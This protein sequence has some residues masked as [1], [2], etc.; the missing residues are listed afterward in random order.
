MKMKGERKNVTILFTDISDFT[1]MSEKLDPEDVIN[2]INSCFDKLTKIIYR[3]EGTVDK[4]MGDCIIALFGAPVAHEDDPERAVK[5]AIEIIQTLDELNK[6][7]P[8][9]IQMHV[10]INTGLVVAGSIGSDLRKQYTVIGDTMNTASRIQS[11]AKR[12]QILVGETVYKLTKDVFYYNEVGEIT[13]KGKE[14]PLRVYAPL[15][16]RPQLT[17]FGKAMA[18]GLT[19]YIGREKELAILRAL[20]LRST[21]GEGNAVGI[22]G[23]P[24]IG[25]SRLLYE[26]MY[27]LDSVDDVLYL[28]GH[29]IP[30]GRISP[31]QPFLEVVRQFLG[32]S[33]Q[34]AEKE[35]GAFY[36]RLDSLKEYI[37]C[38]EDLLS[39]PPSNPEYIQL[40]P[41]VRRKKIFDA[42]IALFQHAAASKPLILVIEDIQWVDETSREF[43]TLLL[44]RISSFRILLILISRPEFNP[45]W[46][47]HDF[48]TSVSLSN[49]YGSEGEC[50]VHALFDAPVSLELEKFI[51]KRVEGNPFFTE[52]LIRVLRETQAVTLNGSYTLAVPSAK[53]NIPE[54]IQGVLAARIDRLDVETKSTL[55]IA[56][57]VGYET[58][59][60][61]LEKVSELKGHEL[62][63]QLEILAE[64]GFMVSQ[65]QKDSTYTFKHALTKEVAY[66]TLLKSNRR[67]LHKE[68]GDLIKQMLPSTVD[69]QPELVAYHYTEAGLLDEAIYYWHLGGKKAI[70]RSSNIEAKGHIAK[71]LEL[72]KSV[73]N[74][75][76]RIRQEV[77]L[78]TTLG[79]A[80]MATKGPANTEVKKVYDRARVLCEQVGQTSQLFPVLF[81]L[82]RFYLLRADFDPARD[83]AKK[84]LALALQIE[85]KGG[86]ETP[87]ILDA[88]F[89]LGVTL[90]WRGDFDLAHRNFKRVIAL[91]DPRQHSNHVFLLGQDPLFVCLCYDAFTQWA[92]GYSD[93]ALE[94]IQAA[95]TMAQERNHP[96]SLAY[97]LFGIA[98]IYQLCLNID[99][100]RQWAE[101][102]IALSSDKGFPYFSSISGILRGWAIARQGDITEGITQINHCLRTLSNTESEVNKTYYLALLA[103]AHWNNSEIEEGLSVLAEAVTMAEK[104][105]EHWYEAELLR[106]R[107]N[108]LLVQDGDK[109]KAEGCFRRSLEVA[110]RQNAISF[111]LRTAI[112]LCKLWQENDRSREAQ[113]LLRNIY[114]RFSEGFGTKDLQDARTLLEALQ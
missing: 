94:K 27:N 102:A 34:A 89:A 12:G 20:F 101:K 5:T 48:Y 8:F 85:H 99:A 82:W 114:E 10:G 49:L 56:S 81:G 110:R 107:G 4:Y 105:K 111:E 95:V 19:P 50:L 62:K 66:G 53:L 112:S 91:Y 36:K 61:I 57:V 17:R 16:I 76:M 98:K 41:P 86:Q 33:V 74:S 67:K 18:K 75:P 24:G 59:V 104:S 21:K 43:L 2:I 52:E 29:C 55:Q 71:G 77:E 30:H 7:L 46:Q 6:N 15:G 42:L 68:V 60:L 69:T 64:A 26:F 35:R 22:S 1:Q 54:T 44:N 14:R 84:L 25:K 83:L 40:A 93:Q 113:E 3:Y 80:L 51:L 73:P 37:P 23:D 87:F 58:D 39:F 9:P 103:E 79:P 47:K 11:A 38:Y 100:T 90:F 109:E 96:F 65:T 108:L 45:P 78:L 92:L 106:L 63:E 97:A 31:Y 28:E 13:V 72:L 88:Y 70:E 32:L